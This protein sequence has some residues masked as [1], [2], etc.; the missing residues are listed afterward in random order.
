LLGLAG[1]YALE[2]LPLFKER[3]AL[4][5]AMETLEMRILIANPQSPYALA[6]AAEEGYTEQTYGEAVEF[7]LGRWKDLLGE[8]KAT[9]SVRFYSFW[10]VIMLY[11][12]GQHRILSMPHLPNTD[13]YEL[14]AVWHKSES[15]AFD[16]YSQFLDREWIK[17]VNAF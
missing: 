17:A 9:Q 11:R 2:E 1:V 5:I 8:E 14:P 12:F 10:P 16:P 3:A 15:L 4:A 13:G 7:A 6:R